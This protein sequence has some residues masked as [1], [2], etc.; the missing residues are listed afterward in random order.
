MNCLAVG[1]GEVTPNLPGVKDGVGLNNIGSLVKISGRV[2]QVVSTYVYVD[3]GSNIEDISGRIGVM[4][5]CPSTPSVNV[6]DIVSVTG[7]VQG[8]VPTGWTAN[9]RYMQRQGEDD[10]LVLNV[11]VNS[12]GDHQH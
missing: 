1:G 9:R 6:G 10:L 12:G 8:S 3:D 7:I 2:T 4:V 5:K 11:A